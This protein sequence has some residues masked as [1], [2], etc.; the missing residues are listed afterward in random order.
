VATTS[1]LVTLS[2]G[3]ATLKFAKIATLGKYT[4]KVFYG[5]SATSPSSVTSKTFTVVK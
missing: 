4:V 3:K 1:A 2:A 5:G